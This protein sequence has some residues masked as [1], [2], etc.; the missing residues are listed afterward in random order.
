MKNKKG[1]TMVELLGAIVILG[2]LMLVAIPSV[3]T[4][5]QKSKDRYYET[6]KKQLISATKDYLKNNKVAPLE[7]GDF[8]DVSMDELVSKKYINVVKDSNK[9]ECTGKKPDSPSDSQ[10][11]TF[12]RVV[13]ESDRLEY[14][15]HLWCPNYK[16]KELNENTA[17]I[18][19]AVTGAI[20]NNNKVVIISITSNDVNIKEYSYK[21]FTVNNSTLVEKNGTVNGMSYTAKHDLTRYLAEYDT[22]LVCYVRVVDVDGGIYTKYFNI[23]SFE[24]PNVAICTGTSTSWNEDTNILKYQFLCTSPNGCESDVYKGQFTASTTARTETITIKDKVDSRLNGTCKINVP[25]KV[26]PPTEEVIPITTTPKKGCPTV[27][28]R[29]TK[30]W[31][32]S[33]ITVTYR[34]SQATTGYRRIVKKN[35]GGWSRKDIL[36]KNKVPF[37]KDTTFSGVGS[38]RDK[39]V[40][41]SSSGQYYFLVR[42]NEGGSVTLC[43]NS[44]YAY[45]PYKVDKTKPI[46]SSGSVKRVSN[47]VKKLT[48]KVKVKDAH[49]GINYLYINQKSSASASSI[50]KNGKKYASK[51]SVTYSVTNS[52]SSGKHTFYAHV[53]DTAGNKIDKKIGSMSIG[54][55]SAN[56]MH[57]SPK[58]YSVYTW[59]GTC[60]RIHGSHS[61]AYYHLC[62]SGNGSVRIASDF[63]YICPTSPESKYKVVPGW[64]K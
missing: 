23:D 57:R 18:N 31:T 9:Q 15:A 64:S 61:T 17:D 43:P 55:T 13:K 59:C 40:T 19:V 54:N 36:T 56:C 52:Y 37:K 32:T 42:I 44:E 48:I 58:T 25:A 1:F 29:Y 11:Y 38:S 49:S 47:N 34:L 8:I 5:I 12:V 16:D 6:Q 21:I 51:S 60:C 45:G 62:V 53:L 3:S 30:N 22:Q 41:Y 24:K 26:T 39:S 63:K 35:G 4:Y 7:T 10:E 28:K 46:Y 2:V 50:R 27:N 33:S 14:V 20:E